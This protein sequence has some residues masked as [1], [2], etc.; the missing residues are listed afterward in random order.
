MLITSSCY[1]NL[2]D[3]L[4]NCFITINGNISND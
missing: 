4:V 1:Y 3:W 2:P